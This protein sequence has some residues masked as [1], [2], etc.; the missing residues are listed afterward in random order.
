MDSLPAGTRSGILLYSAGVFFFAVNDALGKWLVADYGV[1]QIM[2]LRMIGACAILIPMALTGRLSLR[3]RSQYGLHALRVMCS[4]ADTFCFYY[5]T[6]ALPLADVMT[7]YM[8]APLFILAL[9]VP[10]LGERVGAVRWAAVACGFVGVVIALRPGTDAISPSALIALAGSLMFAATIT[11][12]R[13]LRGTDW[14]TLVAYQVIGSGLFGAATSA[15]GWVT[16]GVGDMGLM[17]TVGIVSMLCFMGITRAL[18]LAPASVLAP[19]QYAAI[20]WAALM[21]WAVWG[22][23]P[24]SG[25]VLGGA[26]IV[27]SGLVALRPERAVAVA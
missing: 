18:A 5:A 23:V 7:F 25:I 27:V 6:R 10:F 17:A 19:L 22:D 3:V 26:L 16:P 21:G 1:S 12:T 13:K 8:A 15:F 24:R 4:M 20:L 14:R 9:S 11:T 2:F